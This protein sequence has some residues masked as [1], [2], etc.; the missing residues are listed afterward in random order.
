[1][2]KTY[3]SFFFL[4]CIFQTFLIIKNSIAYIYFYHGH[5][6]LSPLSLLLK[7]QAL[8]LHIPVTYLSS[9]APSE[10]VLNKKQRTTLVVTAVRISNCFFVC[11]RLKPPLSFQD[12]M[13][14]AR[15]HISHFTAVRHQHVKTERQGEV[16][17]FFCFFSCR[18]DLMLSVSHTVWSPVTVQSVQ[19]MQKSDKNTGWLMTCHTLQAWFFTGKLFSSLAQL[20]VQGFQASYLNSDKEIAIQC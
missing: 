1:M 5:Y 3:V 20:F 2:C 19:P 10:Q 17:Y 8:N 12:L 4:F 14:S 6:A 16:C 13:V 9:S 11:L 7:R 18:R 15:I